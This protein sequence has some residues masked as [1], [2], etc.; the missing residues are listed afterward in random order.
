MEASYLLVLGFCTWT[1]VLLLSIG[2]Y[3]IGL[4]LLGK[5]RANAFRSSNEDGH[6]FPHRLGRAH[7]NCCENLPILLGVILYAFMTDHIA[8]TNTFAL[9]FLGLR[10][11]QSITHIASVGIKAVMLRFTLF[12]GQCAILIYWLF[13]LWTV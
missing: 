10:V 4:T 8:I 5:R 2:A 11:G 13:C 1:M 12:A 7:A 3:R 6:T 9:I